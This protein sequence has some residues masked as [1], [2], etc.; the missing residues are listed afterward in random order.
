MSDSD[1]GGAKEETVDPLDALYKTV[2]EAAEFA[3]GGS[4]GISIE[5]FYHRN[6]ADPLA[7]L[8]KEATGAAKL[9]DPTITA[10]RSHGAFLAVSVL[11]CLAIL[12]WGYQV[13]SSSLKAWKATAASDADAP[14]AAGPDAQSHESHSEPSARPIADYGAFGDSLAPIAVFGAV[15]AV[16]LSTFSSY[17]QSRDLIAQLD[18]MTESRKSQSDMVRVQAIQIAIS[19]IDLLWSRVAPY[20]EDAKVRAER[21]AR[22]EWWLAEKVDFLDP[23]VA[24][25]FKEMSEG[26]KSQLDLCKRVEG[27]LTLA[28]VSCLNPAPIWSK[29]FLALQQTVATFAI[30]IRKIEHDFEILQVFGSIDFIPVQEDIGPLTGRLSA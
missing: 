14:R 17:L 3:E 29:R 4:D 18:E 5:V 22:M 24:G 27:E 7:V 10:R 6:A 1:Q 20:V 8:N 11:A 2:E 30:Q 26:V 23:E 15:L 13:Y 28:R 25:K 9:A 21:V 19:Q 16:L 12:W